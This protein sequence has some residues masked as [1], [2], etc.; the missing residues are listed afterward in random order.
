MSIFAFPEQLARSAAAWWSL[1]D[2][3]P[4]VNRAWA[5]VRDELCEVGL[6]DDGVFLDRIE[7]EIEAIASS[8]G[9]VGVFFE[10]P[11]AAKRLIGYREGVIYLPCD[12]PTRPFK[13]GGTLTDIIRHEYAHAW[14]W[15]NPELFRKPWFEE[16]FGASYEDQ[17]PKPFLRWVRERT[18]SKEP[19]LIAMEEQQIKQFVFETKEGRKQLGQ[20]FATPYAVVSA[21]EDFADTFMLY[22]RKHDSLDTYA[23]RPGVYHKVLAVEGAVKEQ[24]RRL[25]S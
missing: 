14:R 25:S 15:M 21:L 17:T 8:N 9:F 3:M 6:L 20:D 7:L 13:P 22:L 2:N 24:C 4:K 10:E 18:H 1:D 23:D 12:L 5:Q 16:T 11:G 19:L